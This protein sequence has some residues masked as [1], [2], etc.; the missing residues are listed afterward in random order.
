MDALPAEPSPPPPASRERSRQSADEKPQPVLEALPAD[1][2]VAEFVVEMMPPEPPEPPLDAILVAVPAIPPPPP[3]LPPLPR[4]TNPIVLAWRFFW[5][6]VGTI[7]SILEWLFG[8]AVLMIGL[9]ALAA[10]PVLQFLSLGYLLEAG[11]RVARSGR[12]REAFIGVRLAA[13][14]GG[15][16]VGSW[17][18]LLPVRLVSGVAQSA[19][20][21]D[22]GGSIARGWRFG[23]LVLIGL[24]AL[25]IA[26]AC[27]R[28]GRLRYFIWPFNVIWLL[29]RFLRGGYYAEARDAVWDTTCSLRLPYYFW[30]GFRGFIGAFAWLAL[31]VTLI[32]L[33]RL[34]NAALLG[35]LGVLALAAVLLYLPFLQMRMAA[36]NRLGSA[37]EICAVRR[38]FKRAPWA[39]TLAFVVTLLSALPLYLLKIEMVPREAAWLPSLVFIA[40]IFPSRV[41][42][43]WAL[44][45]ARRRRTPRHW[46]FRW[47]GRLPVLPAV[48]FYVLVVYFTQFTSWNGIWSLYEQHAFLVPVP[49]FGM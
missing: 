4:E 12:L 39:F 41:L 3:P 10:L 7:G 27:A 8:A 16:V 17:L 37:F 9:A 14:L 6:I 43:G 32:A 2:P 1:L 24:T 38:G 34:P 13:R 49:F 36:T 21:I 5:W 23:L 20:M 45:R 44:S 31:P 11:G 33:G 22:P 42:T 25:H 47:T 28:G 30:L 26:A 35:F 48:G 46:F 19:Q 40:F 29:R 15:I 18:L